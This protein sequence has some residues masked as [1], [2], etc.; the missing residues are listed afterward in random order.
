[1]KQFLRIAC[2]KEFCVPNLG[3]L[4]ALGLGTQINVC[5]L[6]PTRVLE[7]C[8]PSVWHIVGSINIY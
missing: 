6:K 2:M 8:K 4:V 3:A 7:A 5:F 1:M